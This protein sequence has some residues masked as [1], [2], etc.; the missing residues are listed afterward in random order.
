ML[1]FFPEVVLNMDHLSHYHRGI[2]VHSPHL[3]S[4][5]L[6]RSW[7][8]W[9]CWWVHVWRGGCNLCL[10]LGRTVCRQNHLWVHVDIIA[11]LHISILTYHEPYYARRPCRRHHASI[12]WRNRCCRERVFNSRTIIDLVIMRRRAAHP[13]SWSWCP[14]LPHSTITRRIIGL[15]YLE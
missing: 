7:W 2:R 5:L 11:R 14:V 10:S 8:K 9:W 1:S 6:V 4:P 3:E 12:Y 15:L 13:A